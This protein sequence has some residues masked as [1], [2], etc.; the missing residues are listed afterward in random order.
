MNFKRVSL[1]LSIVLAPWTLQALE[2]DQ[3]AAIEV[4][5]DAID[6]DKTGESILSGAVR[7][8]QGSLVI[9]ADSATIYQTQ[10]N[11][12][13]RI[14][15]QGGPV[16]LVQTLD[17]E[18]EIR[19]E[20]ASVDYRIAKQLLVLQGSVSIQQSRGDI[21]GDRIEYNLKTSKI[22]AVGELEQVKLTIQPKT[23]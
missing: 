8:R 5:A 1:L 16:V 12:M 13:S 22:K 6:A 7:I 4:E 10:D 2:S 18:G 17:D 15:L 9:D 20:A 19:V 11:Q 14:Y 21:R 23:T 3:Y